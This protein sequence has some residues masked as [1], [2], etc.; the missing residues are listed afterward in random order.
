MSANFKAKQS[1]DDS[2]LNN[3]EDMPEDTVDDSA[4]EIAITEDETVSFGEFGV[5]LEPQAPST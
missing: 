2:D 1:L 5:N 4:D 3:I